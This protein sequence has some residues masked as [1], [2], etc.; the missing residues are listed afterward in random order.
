MPIEAP[1]EWSAVKLRNTRNPPNQGEGGDADGTA[2]PYQVK[3]K[4]A[5][6]PEDYCGPE[7]TT[8]DE[9]KATQGGAEKPCAE[10]E[11]ARARLKKVSHQV[12]CPRNQ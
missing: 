11:A 9:G 2:G 10:Y 1:T 3:L 12:E 8:H 6:K 4:S 5:P 7:T